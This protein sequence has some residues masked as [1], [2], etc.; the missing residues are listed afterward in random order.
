MYFTLLV[1][2]LKEKFYEGL[3]IKSIQLLS[4]ILIASKIHQTFSDL[5]NSLNVI[6]LNPV[7]SGSHLFVYSN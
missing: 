1:L 6:S 3:A 4:W 2:L 7:M 5:F